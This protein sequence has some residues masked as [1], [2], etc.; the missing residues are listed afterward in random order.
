VVATVTAASTQT[1]STSA[2]IPGTTIP[3]RSIDAAAPARIARALRRRGQRVDYLVL[4]A[5]TGPAEWRAYTASGRIYRA[6][7]RGRGLR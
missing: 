7:R 4:S 5:L 3:L 6:D 2:R 1:I